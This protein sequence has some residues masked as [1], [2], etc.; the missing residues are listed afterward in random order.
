[1]EIPPV[2]SLVVPAP[3]FRD[4][5]GTGDGA[6]LLLDHQRGSAHL[7]YPGSQRAFWVHLRN[8][9]GIP[10]D[11]VPPSSLEALLHRLLTDA[12]AET[13]E[14]DD[15]DG[16]FVLSMTIPRLSDKQLDRILTAWGPRVRSYSL[17]PGNM[18][19]VLLRLDLIN[20]PPA[21]GGGT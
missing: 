1:M 4:A 19:S 18:H 20:L 21:H 6:A 7:Y 5:M 17:E 8:V 9:R 11:A 2:G 15:M 3:S 14:I 12:S 16:Q 13:C 10:P